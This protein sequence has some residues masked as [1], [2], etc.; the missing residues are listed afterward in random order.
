MNI[1]TP[2][3]LAVRLL[4]E[5]T[6]DIAEGIYRLSCKLQPRW[7]KVEKTAFVHNGTSLLEGVAAF[8]S[9]GD[10]ENL[11]RFARDTMHVR[12]LGGFTAVDFNVAVHAYMP[13]IRKA[14]LSRAPTL[15]QGVAAYDVAEAVTL[16]L[17]T[18]LVAAIATAGEITTPDAQP[19]FHG[20]PFEEISVDENIPEFLQDVASDDDSAEEGR[21]NPNA[22]FPAR[23]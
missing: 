23:R 5:N 19:P 13:V 14:F 10:V 22:K 6:K 3:E 16:P 15:R 12:R 17:I 4:R 18:R 1:E 8:M 11:F 21:T 9:G 20:R 2:R 7:A